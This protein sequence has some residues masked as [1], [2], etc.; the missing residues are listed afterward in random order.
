MTE[1]GSVFV[2]PG[3]PVSDAMGSESDPRRTVS[4]TTAPRFPYSTQHQTVPISEVVITSTGVTENESCKKEKRQRSFAD[5]ANQV[6]GA[7]VVTA[8]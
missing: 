3:A 6:S 4:R 1:K 8:G 2:T 7:D 5:T